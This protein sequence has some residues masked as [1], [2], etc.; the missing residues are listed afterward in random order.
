MQLPPVVCSED[1]VKNGHL[2]TESMGMLLSLAAQGL[3]LGGQ[4]RIGHCF[5]ICECASV[6]LGDMSIE[7]CAGH[8]GHSV[9]AALD[10][11]PVAVHRLSSYQCTGITNAQNVVKL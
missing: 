11:P 2:S 8:S 4:L 3:T 5:H 7:F 6:P 9:L 1:L 10:A